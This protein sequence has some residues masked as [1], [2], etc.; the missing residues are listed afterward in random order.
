M[1]L[2]SCIL[3]AITKIPARQD[4]KRNITVFLKLTVNNYLKI[5]FATTANTCWTASR[6]RL[7]IITV[8]IKKYQAS[9]KERKKK[10]TVYSQ[11]VLSNTNPGNSEVDN[12]GA[13]GAAIEQR[14]EA[15]QSFQW[16][17]SVSTRKNVPMS[18]L[19]WILKFVQAVCN[20]CGWCCFFF[21]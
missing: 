15:W 18:L 20:F 3:S 11:M 5:I 21:K 12:Q 8:Y 14:V 4:K 13:V 7:L 9:S 10:T 16:R 1:E 17:V 19:S 6:I 2:P